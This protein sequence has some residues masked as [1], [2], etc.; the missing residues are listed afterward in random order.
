MQNGS[1][2][3]DGTIRLYRNPESSP[4]ATGAELVISAGNN[5]DGWASIRVT[6]S[7]E[8]FA[9]LILRG[10]PQCNV[11]IDLSNAQLVLS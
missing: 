11:E 5:N 10:F 8:D 3:L 9:Q 7:A 4:N 2:K 1:Y 6:L